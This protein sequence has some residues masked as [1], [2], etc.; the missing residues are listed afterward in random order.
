MSL[1]SQG[2]IT[3]CPLNYLLMFTNSTIRRLKTKKVRSLASPEKKKKSEHLAA[4]A[5]PPTWGKWQLPFRRTRVSCPSQRSLPLPV[6]SQRGRSLPA[7]R[8]ISPGPCRPRG[9]PPPLQCNSFQ[10][11]RGTRSPQKLND[12]LLFKEPVKTGLCGNL[13]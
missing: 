3:D 2:V 1:G 10:Y 6:V 11:G 5:L 7:L 12:L 4:L 13:L 9:A 8:S